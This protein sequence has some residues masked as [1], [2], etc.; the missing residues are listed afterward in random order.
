MSLCPTSLGSPP[1]TPSCEGAV[2]EVAHLA[3]V[4]P[5]AA[6]STDHTLG[7]LP[8]VGSLTLV[9]GVDFHFRTVEGV[10]KVL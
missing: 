1:S 10:W 7:D 9:L 4:G 6:A 8:W 2:S 5:V 3:R